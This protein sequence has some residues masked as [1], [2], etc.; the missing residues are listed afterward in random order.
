MVEPKGLDVAR[1][2]FQDW[3]LPY[4]RTEFP[5]ISER[6][7]CLVCGGSQSLGNDDELSR[8]HGWGPSFQ[9][10]LTNEDARRWGRK[11]TRKINDAAPREWAGMKYRGM[12]DTIKVYSLSRWF[13]ELGTPPHPP[14][15]AK[16]WLR[17]QECQLYIFRHAP[18]FH[19]PLGELTARKQA[20]HF[21]PREAW[22]QRISD[23]TFSVWHYGEYNFID[24]MVYRRDSAAIAICLGSFIESTMKLCLLLNEDYAPYWKW[25]AAEFRKVPNIESLD[26][27]ILELT[28]TPTVESQAKLVK[29]ICSDVFFRLADKGLV[30]GNPDDDEHCLKIAKADLSELMN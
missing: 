27:L 12:N 7:A 24:R 13:R 26:A 22:L 3:A 23:E 9:I 8:D 28:N 5:Q 21:Y 4:L 11:L 16:S 10:V 19:D 6:C 18:I 30:K 14:K 2:F 29:R 17:I 25:L 15:D 1:G 20:F